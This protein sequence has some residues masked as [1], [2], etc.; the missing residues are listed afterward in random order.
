MADQS[1][2]PEHPDPEPGE[3]GFGP[4]EH[5]DSIEEGREAATEEGDGDPDSGGEG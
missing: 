4:G 1:Q 3:G 5:G 2:D